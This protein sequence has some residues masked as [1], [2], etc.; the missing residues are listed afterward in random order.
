MNSLKA[1]PRFREK[2]PDLVVDKKAEPAAVSG[3]GKQSVLGSFYSRVMAKLRPKD[4]DW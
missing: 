1:D 3:D 2:Y 4:G